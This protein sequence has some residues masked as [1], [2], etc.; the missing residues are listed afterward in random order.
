MLCY[1]TIR[2]ISCVIADKFPHDPEEDMDEA[3]LDMMGV[4]EPEK[5]RFPRLKALGE[6]VLHWGRILTTPS[7]SKNP[8]FWP[9]VAVFGG[10]VAYFIISSTSPS[11]ATAHYHHSTVN[12][13]LGPKTT[14]GSY[15]NWPTQS[16]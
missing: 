3:I 10:M 11:A 5:T 7:P 15:K 9:T 8:L 13:P 2:R 4:Q 12:P 1:V 6:T 16:S 14:V